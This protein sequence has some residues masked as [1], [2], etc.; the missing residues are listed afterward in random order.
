MAAGRKGLCDVTLVS[1]DTNIR[2]LH[3]FIVLGHRHRISIFYV[4]VVGVHK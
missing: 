3:W 4:Y 1:F 2:K